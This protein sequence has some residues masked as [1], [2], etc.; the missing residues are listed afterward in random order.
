MKDFVSG[1]VGKPKVEKTEGR[2]TK[3]YSYDVR[4]LEREFVAKLYY[5]TK[6]GR[7]YTLAFYYP[8][9]EKKSIQLDMELVIYSLEY[10]R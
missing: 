4:V 9:A 6:H 1:V 8:P 2:L 7:F 3:L 5:F 10:G